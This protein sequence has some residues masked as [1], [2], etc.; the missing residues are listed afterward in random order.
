[1]KKR[2]KVKLRVVI[3]VVVAL[4]S[5]FGISQYASS[6]GTY[7]K[8]I[9]SLDDKKGTATGLAASATAAS[10]AVSA[11]PSDVAT[12]IADE[13]AELSSYFIIILGAIYLEKY[14]L[15]II[16]YVVFKLLIPIVCCLFIIDTVKEN[17]QCRSIMRKLVSIGLVAILVIPGSEKVSTLIQS[18]YD[19]TIQETIDTVSETIEVEEDEEGGFSAIWSKVKGGVTG[20]VDTVKD[21]LNNF[22]EAIAVMIVTTCVIP[23]ITML[24]FIWA[25]KSILGVNINIPE[26]ENLMIVKKGIRK[27]QKR[28]NSLTQSDCEYPI[29]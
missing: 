1:M 26:K 10:V 3:A 27:K 28:E 5:F 24:F 19:S 9:A 6:P 15:T 25:I 21:T 12:P 17:E 23:I 13:L 7:K 11:I 20:A 2:S 18:T 8:T 29:E 4:I 14:L 16:G 22:I